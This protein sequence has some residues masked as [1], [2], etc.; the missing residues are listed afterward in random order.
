MAGPQPARPLVAV[1][2]V[3]A[4]MIKCRWC[5]TFSSRVTSEDADG[6]RLT[7]A[8]AACQDKAASRASTTIIN[9]L[10]AGRAVTV[11]TEYVVVFARLIVSQ[12]V[13]STLHCSL[14]GLGLASGRV[15]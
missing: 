3:T 13:L 12:T 7:L 4:S 5:N 11:S 15:A 10:P 8:C 14:C 2:N 9:C 6:M 1:P